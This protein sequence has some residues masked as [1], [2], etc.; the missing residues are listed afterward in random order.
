MLVK[1]DV[2]DEAV[3]SALVEQYDHTIRAVEFLPVGADRNSASYRAVTEHGESCFIKLRRG[4]F[5]ETSVLLPRF[6]AGRG[7]AN[8]V[9][10]LETQDGRLWA[11]LAPWTLIVYPFIEGRDGYEVALSQRQ[12]H[13]I[14]HALRRIH[15]VELPAALRDR[16]RRETFPTRW[17]R[18]LRAQVA[19][20]GDAT[21]E[22]PIAAELACFLSAKKGLLLDLTGRVEQLAQVLQERSPEFVLCHSDVH[23]GNVLIEA[24]GPIYLV[25]WDDPIIAPKERDLMF[26]GGGYWGGWL[27]PQR[28]VTFFYRGYGRAPIDRLAL[29]YYRYGRI[30]EDIALF[31]A[32]IVETK[33]GGEDRQQSLRYLTSSFLPNH[34]IELAYSS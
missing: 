6:L 17:A 28:E 20:A 3:L 27:A 10:P 19:W 23:A 26:V 11:S 2:R 29:A 4:P 34:T 25:D 13:D 1:P 33:E 21:P 24:A 16:I 30:V 31:S 22:D 12:W 32:H 9:S 18:E 7:I 8:I 14:G 15:T 5:D